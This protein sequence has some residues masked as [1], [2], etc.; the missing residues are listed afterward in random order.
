MRQGCLAGGFE[1][2]IT[3]PKLQPIVHYRSGWFDPVKMFKISRK[4]RLI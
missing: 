3:E 4:K 2:E 1:L